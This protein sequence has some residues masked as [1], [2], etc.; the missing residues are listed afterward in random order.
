MAVP[1]MISS[2]CDGVMTF[3]DR[4]FLSK[5]GTEHMNAAMGGYVSYLMLLFFF[6]GLAGYSTAL[7]AQYFGAEQKTKAP[8]VTFQAIV[9]VL[10]AWPIVILLKPLVIKLF[11]GMNLPV[12]QAIL[13]E[14]YLTILIQGAIFTLLRHVMSCYFTGI[15]KARVVMNATLAALIV[16]VILDYVLIFGAFGFAAMGIKGAAIA[17][18]TGNAFA[19]VYFLFAYFS[20]NNLVTFAVKKSFHFNAGI[21][22]RLVK[23][24][25]P[26]G[27]EIFLSFVAF[28]FMTLM[29]QSQ[30]TVASTATS[31]MFSYDMMSFIPLLGIEIAATSLAARYMGAER[32][33]LAEKT[34]WSAVKTGLLYSSVVLLL[35]L[36]IPEILV[37]VFQPTLFNSAFEAA[38]PL[39]VTMIRI[40]ALY[41]LVQAVMISLIGVL[42]GAGDTFYTMLVNVGANWLFLP[43]QYVALYVFKASVPFVWFLL[44]LIFLTFC[45]IMY[46]RFK[47]GKWKTL[48]ILY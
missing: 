19:F 32:P 14:Q 8:I 10:L 37:R 39:A 7:V 22:L 4:L 34:A 20:H 43:I 6:M 27:L 17:T 42:R 5:V 48:R 15:G 41:V 23:Y 11:F 13:Q 31:I 18:V 25:Y 24:G 26:A 3:T 38:V 46:K 9:I 33:D 36:C 44:V 1:M 21:M 28:F 40:A 2:A 12:D 30:G 45:F 16:N 35:F 29:F 47:T